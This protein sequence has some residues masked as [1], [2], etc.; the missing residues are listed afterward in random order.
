[1]NWDDVHFTEGYEKWRAYGQSKTANVLFAVGLDRRSAPSGVHAYSCH[2]GSI[3]TPLQRHFTREEM[4]QLGWTDAQGRGTDPTF[5]TPPQGA[6][7]AVWA[8][9]S[10]LLADAGPVYC[11]DADVADAEQVKPWATDPA[12]AERLWAYSV[13]LTGVDAFDA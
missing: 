7:T 6:A 4:V 10:P 8:A 13:E 12:E 1:M 5:K 2:H 9:T 11:V 3:L